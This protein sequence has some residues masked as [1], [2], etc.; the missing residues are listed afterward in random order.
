MSLTESIVED[1]ALEM[2]AATLIPGFSPWEKE[3]GWRE[4]ELLKQNV[5]VFPCAFR[6]FYYF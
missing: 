5:L 1:A 6:A 4:A 2:P 3:Q